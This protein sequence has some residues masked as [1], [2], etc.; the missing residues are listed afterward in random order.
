MRRGLLAIGAAAAATLLAASCAA[1][2]NSLGTSS[3][4]CFRALPTAQ[5]AVHHQ[6]H[7]VGVRRMSRTRVAD[8]L[9]TSPPPGKEFCVVGFSGPFRPDQVDRPASTH[10]GKYAVVV[11]TLRGTT[12]HQ[13]FLVD[14][15]PTRLRHR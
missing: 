2:R 15:L 10:P 1:P 4:T 6:G 14:R 5:A 7:F 8:L 13:T 9:H 11:V 12:A 3:S